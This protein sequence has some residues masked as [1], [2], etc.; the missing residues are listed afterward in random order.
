MHTVYSFTALCNDITVTAAYWATVVYSGAD[1]A[2][3]GVASAAV[4]NETAVDC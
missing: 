4:N 3:V 1:F 2:A